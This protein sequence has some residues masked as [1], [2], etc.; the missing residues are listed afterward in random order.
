[1]M[2][3]WV[4]RLLA[5]LPVRRGSVV[6]TSFPDASDN[7]WA[8]FKY[9]CENAPHLFHVWLVD[10]EFNLRDNDLAGARVIRRSTIRAVLT[11]ARAEF[12]FHT[13][14]IYRFAC[15]RQGQAIV[16]LWHGMP[17]KTIGTFDASLIRLPL[18]DYCIATSDFFRRIMAR[19]FAM[20]L[21]QVLITGQPRNDLLAE[22]ARLRPAR[23]ALW[24]PT[25][26]RS[27]AGDI[28]QDSTFDNLNITSLLARIDEQLGKVGRRLI[29]KLHPMDALNEELDESF[30]NIMVLRRHDPAPSVPDL[31]AQAD[32]L[33]TDFSSA[34]IDYAILGRPIG[35]YCPDRENY[36]R[37]FIDG[38]ADPYFRAGTD[39]ANPQD[40]ADFFCAP[41][42]PNAR[43]AELNMFHDSQ[44]ASRLWQEITERMY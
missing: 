43:V 2:L 29:L 37:G 20:E 32:C 14:G 7:A 39:L 27:I 26:R 3:G 16:N 28:R 35:F 17:L 21:D 36:L 24:M 40:L 34:A 18:G 13:H 6:F 44:S 8:M 11:M 42:Q 41:P 33:V 31:M 10:R 4:Y 5:W 22:A 12:V 38:V 15:R 25:Y 1:M 9:L 30:D 19:A 23:Y